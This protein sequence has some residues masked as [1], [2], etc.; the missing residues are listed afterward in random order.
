MYDYN[1]R[2]PQAD[3]P[4]S[5]HEFEM[6][7]ASASSPCSRPCMLALFHDCTEPLLGKD[8]LD[9]IPKRKTPLEMER[10]G[11]EQAWGIQAQHVISFVHMVFY[12]FLIIAGTFG[13]W[14]WW[15]AKHPDEIQNAAVPVT[16][17]LCLLSLFWSTAGVLK[18][19]R[20]S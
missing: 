14:G 18:I 10:N 8:A 20:E 2:P 7:L 13:F 17:M 9:S 15:Q 12:H 19:F 1:P 16:T 6:A 11:R 5:P 3:P 4:I